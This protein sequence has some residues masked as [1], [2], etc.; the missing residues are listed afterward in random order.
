MA[1]LN[2]MEDFQRDISYHVLKRDDGLIG[3]SARLNDRYHDIRVEVLVDFETLAVTSAGVDFVRFP[4]RN[5]PNVAERMNDLVGFVIGRGLNRKLLEIFG[6]GEGC[7]NLRVLLLGLLP[8]AMNVK[9]A[10]GFS[11]EQ[12][13]LDSIRERL[14]GSC[15]GYVKSK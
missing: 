4:S 6:G 5:C 1:V 3:L 14:Q 15:A 9:A 7:G 12:E 2:A 10:A 11:D 8:L 13:M